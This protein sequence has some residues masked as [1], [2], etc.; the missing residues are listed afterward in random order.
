MTVECFREASL[1][2]LG[3][4]SEIASDYAAQGMRLTVRQLYYQCV[5]RGDG[6]TLWQM[7]SEGE[8]L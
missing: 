8:F 6:A 2:L 3:S 5:A 1:R 4:L 7:T